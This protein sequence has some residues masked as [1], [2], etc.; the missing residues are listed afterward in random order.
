MHNVESSIRAMAL[1]VKAQVLMERGDLKRA[2]PLIRELTTIR[3]DPLDWAQ[4]GH[5]QSLAGDTVGAI[6]SFQQVLVIAPGQ[7]AIHKA[8][9]PLYER[10]GDSDKARKHRAEARRLPPGGFRSR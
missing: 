6:S 7:G 3:R 5:C 10:A 2:I 9:A 8:L 1:H 4:L